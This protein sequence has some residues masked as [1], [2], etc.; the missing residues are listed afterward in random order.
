[1]SGCETARPHVLERVCGCVYVTRPEMHVCDAYVCHAKVRSLWE[2]TWAVRFPELA[3][4]QV[5]P[6]PHSLSPCSMQA[7]GA[8]VSQLNR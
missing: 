3:W 4:G 5:L 1:M 8:L 7:C 6:L 2:E